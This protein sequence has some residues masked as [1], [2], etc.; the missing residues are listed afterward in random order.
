MMT[1]YTGG[2]LLTHVPYGHYLCQGGLLHQ[3]GRGGRGQDEGAV[4]NGTQHLC[5]RRCENLLLNIAFLF[6]LLLFLVN[7]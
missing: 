4:V 7:L 2:C 6:C 3:L 5:I 1:T